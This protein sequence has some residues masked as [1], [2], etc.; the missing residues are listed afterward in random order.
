MSLLERLI[1]SLKVVEGMKASNF[2]L[3]DQTA[4]LLA[5]YEKA[6]VGMSS[7]YLN[8]LPNQFPN[9]IAQV[10]DCLSCIGNVSKLQATMAAADY[11]NREDELGTIATCLIKLHR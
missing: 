10:D 4:F 7:E 2:M 1:G 3:F 9:L 6:G 8:K 11:Q 5:Q